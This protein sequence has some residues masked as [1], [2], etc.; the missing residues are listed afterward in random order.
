M[1]KS[2]VLSTVWVSATLG[3]V[4]Q[5]GTSCYVY[6]ESVE[7]AGQTV[8]DAPSV[9]QAFQQCGTNGSVILTNNTFHINSVMNTT[10]L[11]NCDVSLYG[12]M[13]WST[14]IAYWRSH[15]YPVGLQNQSTAWL[16]GGTNVAFRGYGQGRLNGQGT[17]WF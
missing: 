10:N 12:E 7:D 3:Y 13:I 9:I 5:N 16:F 4:T 15:G 6:P 14:D 8:D 1:L 17:Q 2:L 11:L